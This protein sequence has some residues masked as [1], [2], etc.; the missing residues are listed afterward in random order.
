MEPRANAERVGDGTLAGKIVDG[1]DGQGQNH[2]G[3]NN[4]GFIS[5]ELRR[6][7][8]NRVNRKGTKSAEQ[9]T[10]LKAEKWGQKDETSNFS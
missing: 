3:Q 5:H 7:A 9:G 8:G 6:F 10:K 2:G 1:D 4:A